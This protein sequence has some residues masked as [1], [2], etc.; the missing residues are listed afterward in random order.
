MADT[1]AG[2][3]PG[4]LEIGRRFLAIGWKWLYLRHHRAPWQLSVTE[5][6]ML[7]RSYA[8]PFMLNLTPSGGFLHGVPAM[9]SA[10]DIAGG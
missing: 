10:L 6:P 1:A 3:R 8:E 2:P 9:G 7:P 5:R 4:G